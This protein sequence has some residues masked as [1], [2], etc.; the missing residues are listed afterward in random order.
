MRT[1]EMQLVL[2]RCWARSAPYLLDHADELG[3]GPVELVEDAV[4]ERGTHVLVGA[5]QRRHVSLQQQRRAGLWTNQR[6]G[7]RSERGGGREVFLQ[8]E[9]MD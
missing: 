3:E 6:S 8:L 5:Q 2:V 4:E 1:M 7:T 9:K